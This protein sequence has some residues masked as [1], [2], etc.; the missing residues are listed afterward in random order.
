[1]WWGTSKSVLSQVIKLE[2]EIS[3]AVGLCALKGQLQ[4]VACTTQADDL[5]QA[6]GEGLCLNPH[7]VDLLY[8]PLS[9]SYYRYMD[10][11]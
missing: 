4:L 2:T 9:R 5:I 6:A 7:R 3:K 10:A 11:H 8:K 1:M